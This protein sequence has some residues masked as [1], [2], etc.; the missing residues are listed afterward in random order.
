MCSQ[1][2]QGH[3][4]RKEDEHNQH[5]VPNLSNGGVNENKNTSITLAMKASQQQA[6]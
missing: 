2:E 6:E 3:V 4:Q 1:L 5:E